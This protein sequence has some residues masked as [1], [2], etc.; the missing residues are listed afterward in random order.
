MLKKAETDWHG[1]PLG[2]KYEASITAVKAL[3]KNQGPHGVKP[4]A[5]KDD[6]PKVDISKVHLSEQPN[7]KLGDRGPSVRLGSRLLA[8]TV[9]H[10]CLHDTCTQLIYALTK[11][12]IFTGL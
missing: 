11:V 2:P 12:C 7:Y 9:F 10:Q 1:K 4:L 8:P 6:A 3:I 5:F